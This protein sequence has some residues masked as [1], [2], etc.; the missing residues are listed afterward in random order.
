ME[1]DFVTYTNSP[2]KTLKSVSCARDGLNYFFKA[3]RDHEFR[4][5]VR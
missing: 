4:N 1:Y 2:L 5:V 3:L